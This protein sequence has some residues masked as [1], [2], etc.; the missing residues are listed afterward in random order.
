MSISH[1]V[2]LSVQFHDET[3]EEIIN[4]EEYSFL[5]LKSKLLAE[6]FYKDK[7]EKSPLHYACENGNVNLFN[8]Y[9][10]LAPNFV[11]V[12]TSSDMYD[13]T[14]LDTAFRSTPLL[15]KNNFITV[16]HC[17]IYL[18][19]SDV[20]CDKFR[21]KIFIPHEYLTFLILKRS[22]RISY[23]ILPNIGKYVK[24]SLQ[25][26]SPHLLA[27]IYYNFPYEYDQYMFTYGVA[28]L[29]NLL[30]HPEINPLLFTFLPKMRY[31][32]SKISGEVIL[33]DIVQD[34]RKTFW[35]SP[36][37]DFNRF[38]ILSSSL[39][40]CVDVNG[41]TFLHRSVIGGNYIAFFFLRQLGMSFSRKTRDGKNLIQ[42]LVDNAPCFKVKDKIRN[43]VLIVFGKDFIVQEPWT[44]N[45]FAS[46]SYDAL[47]LFLAT[48]TRLI[49]QMSLHEICNHASIY[50]SFTH[51]VAAKG[52]TWLLLEIEKHFGTHALNCVNNKN[53]TTA[54]LLHFFNHFNK[55]PYF[56]TLKQY[57]VSIDITTSLFL[58][59]MLD[60]KPF[61]LSKDSLEHKC[62]YRMKNFRNT[63]RMRFCVL[64][65]EK[66]F[67]GTILQFVKVSGIKSQA[68]FDA[69]MSEYYINQYK[70]L[71]KFYSEGFAK[72][73]NAIE[74]VIENR[75]DSCHEKCF[76]YETILQNARNKRCFNTN[77]S[78]NVNSTECFA[79]IAALS[80][81]KFIYQD[82][83]SK[84]KNGKMFHYLILYKDI[85]IIYLLNTMIQ[86]LSTVFL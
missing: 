5:Y 82:M 55:Y 77:S 36:Y 1:Y 73:L 26:N 59:I 57:S 28:S 29:K 83:Y 43:L 33:H 66:E 6:V 34:E 22:N 16:N 19:S 74:N 69:I 42:L 31:D 39:D 41:Y 18:L 40:T 46:F 68:D 75:K 48:E 24:I 9:Q 54:F 37:F 65:M 3:T 58:K 56:W 53:I 44:E 64:N 51:K 45:N 12:S 15:Y 81:F 84:M 50:L 63:H 61:L 23:V 27:I 62:N 10:R 32:C 13:Y 52:L 2:A 21:M 8:F 14:F 11:G 49:R 30:K 17:N 78:V 20:C 80:R 79:L 47:A 60:F 86:S 70:N 38:D 85:Y 67:L 71:S 72:G 35:T 25:K 7:Y 4:H 76:S